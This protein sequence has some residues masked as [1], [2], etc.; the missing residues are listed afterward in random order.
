MEIIEVFSPP[1]FIRQLPDAA[2]AEALSAELVAESQAHPGLRRSN[3]GG[4]HSLPD[5][6]QRQRPPYSLLFPRLAAE[7]TAALTEFGRRRGVVPPPYRYVIQAWAMVMKAGDYTM[8]HEHAEAHL[9]GVYYADAGDAAPDP[10][11]HLAF[12]RPGGAGVALPG[13]PLTAGMF[14]VRPQ[15]GLLVLFP[16]TLQH[17]VHPYQGQRPRVAVAFNVHAEALMGR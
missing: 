6:A 8:L 13:L 4:W 10:S 9:S 17:F 5:L 14:V 15:T 3:V 1:I 7:M 2:L 12:V 11:G 16:G